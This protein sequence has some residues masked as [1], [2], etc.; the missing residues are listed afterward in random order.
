MVA[1]QVAAAL[2][3]RGYG[4]TIR[5][6]RRAGCKVHERLAPNLCVIGKGK[7]PQLR[8]MKK[9]G[10][11]VTTS[12]Q[13]SDTELS[14]HAPQC[15]ESTHRSSRLEAWVRRQVRPIR[16]ERPVWPGRPPQV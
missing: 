3:T 9:S 6:C 10:R 4:G 1:L 8:E 5:P 15:V 12:L 7:P 2:R 16:I 11:Y 14:L 13:V